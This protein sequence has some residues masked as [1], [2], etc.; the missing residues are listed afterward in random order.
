MSCDRVVF[1]DIEFDHKFDRKIKMQMYI[2]V[3]VAEIFFD[4]GKI[5]LTRCFPEITR[6]AVLDIKSESKI[7]KCDL[8]NM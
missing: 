3:S 7:E 6:D 2:D 5:S 1:N 8:Y 4:D